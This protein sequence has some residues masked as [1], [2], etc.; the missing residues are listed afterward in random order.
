M[1]NL[2]IVLFLLAGWQS[3]AQSKRKINEKLKADLIVREREYDSTRI[4]F[5]SLYSTWKSENENEYQAVWVELKSLDNERKSIQEDITWQQ[6]QLTKL[7]V[8]YKEAKKIQPV[9]YEKV[10]REYSGTVSYTPVF[11]SVMDMNIP[12]R[13]LKEQNE[14][15]RVWIS[16]F[17]N[18]YQTNVKTLD[19]LSFHIRQMKIMDQRLDSAV[20]QNVAS[21]YYL[22]KERQQLGDQWNQLKQEYKEKGPKGF[23]PV[24]EE[25]FRDRKKVTNQSRDPFENKSD[26]EKQSNEEPVFE[27][28]DEPAQFPGGKDAMN[29]YLKEHLTLPQTIS[30]G[31]VSE[32]IFVKFIV[33]QKG[34]ISSVSI[35]RGFADCHECSE[36]VIKVVKAMPTWTPAKVNGQ[37]VRSLYTLSLT[38]PLSKQ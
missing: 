8:K 29:N 37:I 38:F 11:E 22:Y 31:T 30:D 36:E 18:A 16:Q 15:L 4:V 13:P 2:L 3:F 27:V 25:V 6:K 20:N 24:Y 14:E 1:K 26:A 32:K 35:V 21:V 34:E 28:V 7:D 9:D 10:L 17:D 19:S 33:S 23:P 5:D 12:K